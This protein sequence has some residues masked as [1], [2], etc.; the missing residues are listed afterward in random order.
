M[1]KLALPFQASPSRRSKCRAPWLIGLSAFVLV[2]TLATPSFAQLGARAHVAFAADRLMGIYIL[3][4]EGRDTTFGLG[5]PAS[6][7]PYQL[8]RF[9]FD[10]FVV[11]HLSLGGAVVWTSQ[12]EGDTSHFLLSPRVG[13]AIDFS[14]SFGF[15][16]RGG[17]TFRNEHFDHRD[18]DEVALTFEAMF[19][20]E[21]AE[22]FAFI[23][24]PVFDIGLAGDGEE[25]RNFGIITF[26]VLGWI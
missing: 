7:H 21:P 10:F 16:P 25:A 20:G 22:H 13:Y 23:F 24:G 8:P 11:D 3:R 6:A 2:A 14:R 15:W 17:L 1:T 9:G 4:G 26:G 5:G 19:Y 18:D 12:N